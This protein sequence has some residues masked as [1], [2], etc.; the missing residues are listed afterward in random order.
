M[1]VSTWPW[2]DG[3]ATDLELLDKLGTNWDQTWNHFCYFCSHTGWA[4][5][6]F[7]ERQM[8]PASH[9]PSADNKRR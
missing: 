7:I 1:R 2:A 3:V 4:E 8:A 6:R 9:S 5:Q